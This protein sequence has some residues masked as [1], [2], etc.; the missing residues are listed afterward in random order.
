[1]TF[2]SKDIKD[3]TALIWTDDGKKHLLLLRVIGQFACITT[4]PF[5]F[6]S[7]FT[8]SFT[9]DRMAKFLNKNNYIEYIAG[10]ES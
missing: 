4:G 7:P 10:D 2:T 9:L 8:T 3:G 6:D 5:E 1:M